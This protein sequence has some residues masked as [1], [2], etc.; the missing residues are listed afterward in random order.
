[1][2]QQKVVQT[3]GGIITN[4]LVY[5]VMK[6]AIESPATNR[7]VDPATLTNIIGEDINRNA[8]GVE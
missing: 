8:T 5:V 7:Q 6:T 1:M 2:S 4:A 3:A